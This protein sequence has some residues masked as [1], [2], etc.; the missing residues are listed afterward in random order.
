MHPPFQSARI[1][2]KN[3][4]VDI[5]FW[6]TNKLLFST[7][8]GGAGEKQKKRGEL[9]TLLLYKQL[10]LRSSAGE[11]L[12]QLVFHLLLN[13]CGLNPYTKQLLSL[14]LPEKDLPCMEHIGQ[15]QI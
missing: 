8:S 4:K 2:I 9:V 13:S 11:K 10:N 1:W 7:R 14:F 6:K 15:T 5:G 3:S 12:H